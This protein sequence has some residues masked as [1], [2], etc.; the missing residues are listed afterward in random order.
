MTDHGLRSA[1][2][3]AYDDRAYDL[4]LPASS[5]LHKKDSHMLA[6]EKEKEME[7]FEKAYDTI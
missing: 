3:R 1:Q 5:E 6:L 7:N 2:V 4:S